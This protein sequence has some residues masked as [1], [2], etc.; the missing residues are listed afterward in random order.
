MIQLTRSGLVAPVAGE[1]DELAGT[2]AREHCVRLR[3]F[4][5]PSILSRFAAAI[6]AGPFVPRVH[7]ELDPPATDLWFSD[8]VARGTLLFFFNDPSLFAF[9]RRLT[10]CGPIGCFIGSVYRMT[11]ELGHADT[12]H[13]DWWGGRLIA[14]SLNLSPVAYRGGLL[15]IR[16]QHSQRIL[17]EVANTGF[18]DAVIFRLST[19]IEHLVTEV[20]PGPAKTAYAG[21]FQ[22]APARATLIRQ[23]AG[24]GS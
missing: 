16:D 23:A 2:F 18:G 24:A 21:W 1:V 19:E 7:D 22:S 9:I 3:G 20:L 10:G 5:E 15:R 12:W 11:A 13:D 17:H 4:L 14:L 8:P 6:E